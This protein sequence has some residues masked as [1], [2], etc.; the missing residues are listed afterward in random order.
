MT[1]VP[2]TPLPDA[3]GDGLA[4]SESRLEVVALHGG[5][6]IARSRIHPGPLDLERLMENYR[7]LSLLPD[8]SFSHTAPASG[9]YEVALIEAMTSLGHLSGI[10]TAPNGE[11][12][13]WDADLVADPVFADRSAIG[14]WL[15]PEVSP[16][17]VRGWAY[18][19]PGALSHEDPVLG[20]RI[21]GAVQALVLA[22]SSGAQVASTSM[23]FEIGNV[24]SRT[25]PPPPPTLAPDISTLRASSRDIAQ[26]GIPQ[27]LTPA[28]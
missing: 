6:T 12:H 3:Q 2:Y 7:V 8:T 26:P 9:R 1:V 13:P 10:I 18:Q 20:S 4:L 25:N 5:K 22:V 16:M 24:F 21:R 28:A 11:R 23:T 14:D 15:P 27:R 19:V 17:S